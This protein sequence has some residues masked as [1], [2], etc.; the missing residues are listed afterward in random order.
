MLNMLVSLIVPVFNKSEYLYDSLSSLSNQSFEDCEFIL[1]DDCSTDD[2]FGICNSFK[3]KDNRFAVLQTNINSGPSVARNL[4]IKYATGDYIGFIDADDLIEPTYV[5]KMINKNNGQDII[6]CSADKVNS[7][8][9]FIRNFPA[10]FEKEGEYTSID[11]W[12]NFQWILSSANWNKLYSRRLIEKTNSRFR[13]VKGPED[14]LFSFDVM[15]Y[16]PKI[17][18]IDDALY[19]YRAVSDSLSSSFKSSEDIMDFD[20]GVEIIEWLYTFYNF[21]DFSNLFNFLVKRYIS[22]VKDSNINRLIIKKFK[23]KLLKLL[24]IVNI[25]FLNKIKL[26]IRIVFNIWK[27]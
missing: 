2:S 17:F 14:L 4:G 10:V 27:K 21:K 11:F 3:N 22:I 18:Y 20:A 16:N 5:E 1:V 12:K 23:K 19:H 13:D 24:N 15:R 6:M 8:G 26:F 9:L 25:P 7:G